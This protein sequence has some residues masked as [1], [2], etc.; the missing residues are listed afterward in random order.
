MEHILIRL[1]LNLHNNI[2]LTPKRYFFTIKSE[3]NRTSKIVSEGKI[4]IT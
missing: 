2:K 3:S 1:V 4:K